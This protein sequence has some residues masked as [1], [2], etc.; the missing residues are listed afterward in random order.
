MAGGETPR[1]LL[2]AHHLV[3]DA[4]SFRILLED[5]GAAYVALRGG[6]RPALP[7][8][9][10]SFATWARRIEAHAASEA[11]SA[12]ARI[13][14]RDDDASA[15]L[16]VDTPGGRNDEAS[17]GE[18]SVALTAEETRVLLQQVPTALRARI[19]ELLLAAVVRAIA[20]WTGNP[21]TRLEVEGHG[22]E[23]LFSGVDVSRTVG[24]FTSLYP[25]DVDLIEPAPTPLDAL[26]ATQQA[27][28]RLPQG[29]RGIRH[30]ALRRAGIRRSPRAPV[31]SGARRLASTTSDSSMAPSPRPRRSRRRASVAA[32][33]MT[34]GTRGPH[35]LHGRREHA[36][37]LLPHHLGLQQR[38]ASARD[39]RARRGRISRH[40]AAAPR[41]GRRGRS[42]R[43]QDRRTFRKRS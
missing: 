32:R 19:G 3:V 12:E 33:P 23:E 42:P 7:A 36:R 39:G 37:R 28:R 34:H 43:R 31:G 41:G 6:G 9:T 25:V 27:L 5:L 17:A 20:L 22:R 1:L 21:R 11:L 26:D 10:T 40:A 18:V 14:L 30:A 4:V 2:V 8:K 15:G 24:W 38:A 13:W 16:P 29:G 35:L